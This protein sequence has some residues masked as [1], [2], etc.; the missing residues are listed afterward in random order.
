MNY[1][2]SQKRNIPSVDYI[3]SRD[4]VHFL[5][6]ASFVSVYCIAYVYV[7]SELYLDAPC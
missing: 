5:V 4:F 1:P 7:V 6:I 3:L 2:V